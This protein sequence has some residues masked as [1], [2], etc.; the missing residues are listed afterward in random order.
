MTTDAEDTQDQNT[1]PAAVV[2]QVKDALENLYDLNYLEHHPLAQGDASAAEHPT[3]HAG[4]RL[5]LELVGA[6]ESLSPGPSVSF[7]APQARVHNLLVLHYVECRTVQEAA[8]MTDVSRRQAHRDLRLGVEK[9]AAI[10]WARRFTITSQQTSVSQLS[11]VETEVA[12]LET[13]PTPTDMC[14][15]LQ[16][17]RETVGR[18]AAQHDVQFQ[19]KAPTHP[20]IVSVDQAVAEQVVVN[21][22]SNAIQQA[23]PGALRVAL[24]SDA[25]QAS[26]TVRYL[27]EPTMASAP[28]VNLVIAKMADQL[29]WVVRKKDQTDGI[30]IIALNMT[31]YGPSVLVIDDNEGLVKLVGRYL[32]DQTCR[33]ISAEDGLEGLRLAEEE[34]PD[35]IILD[36]MIPQVHG[37]EVLQRL[38]N[39]P[40]TARIP[41]IICSVINDPELAYSLGAS[42]FLP[43][44]VSRNKILKALHEL[45]VL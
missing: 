20:V 27:P 17:A 45:D 23:Q 13:H 1:P 31:T 26:L 18:L 25:G 3:G 9:I 7:D 34:L 44:P 41:V 4:Q 16:Q 10:F 24:T 40:E 12:R 11:S 8:H 36:V 5:R 37:W 30:R 28:P 29:G 33:V 21:L 38:R 43:K 22:L 6:I 15:L 2:D 32:T 19:I 14:H 35:V 39:H 42:L